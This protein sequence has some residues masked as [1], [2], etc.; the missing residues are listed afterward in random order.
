MLGCCWRRETGEKSP[1]LP[2]AEAL[3]QAAGPDEAIAQDIYGVFV[4]L[5]LSPVTVQR[6][7]ELFVTDTWLGG[8]SGGG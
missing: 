4:T 6:L 1:G 3:V 7:S 8:R 2:R 5:R